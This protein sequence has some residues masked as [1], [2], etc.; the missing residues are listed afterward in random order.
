MICNLCPN[1][2]NANRE[3]NLGLCL[4]PGEMIINRIAPHYYEEPPISGDRGSGTIFLGGCTM[5]CAFCQNYEIS[6]K[7]KGK[8]TTPSELALKIKE[9]EG[10]EVHNINFVTPTHYSHKIKETLEIYRPSVPVVY[11]TSGYELVE[12]IK[13]L[14]NYVNIYLPDMKYASSDLAKHFSA[15]SNYP[16][17]A[18]NAICEMVKQKKNTYDSM[19]VMKTGVIIRHM[20]LPGHTDDSINVLALLKE[21]LG[22]NITISLMSQFTP[23]ERCSELPKGLKAIEYKL[24]V[25]KATEMGFEDIFTQELTSAEKTYIP[26]WS[27]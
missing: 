7:A 10:L 13:D 23:I 16:E 15:R 9:L 25:N 19:G 27:F 5:K 21:R 14:E 18:I 20:I 24:V 11:N 4:S 2:C 26:T 17:Y 12:E 1:K 6:L 8:T 22:T 3:T